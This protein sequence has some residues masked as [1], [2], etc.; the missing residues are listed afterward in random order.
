M[1]LARVV[2]LFVGAVEGWGRWRGY[3]KPCAKLCNVVLCY[4]VGVGVGVGVTRIS[5]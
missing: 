5:G 4:G 1:W 2:C 3:A